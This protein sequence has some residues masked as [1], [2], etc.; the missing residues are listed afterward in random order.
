MDYTPTGP[1]PTPRQRL[2]LFHWM[3]SDLP[4]NAD[5]W[6]VWFRLITPEKKRG[7]WKIGVDS[8]TRA[9]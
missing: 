7:Y 6:L 1:M 3:Y 5:P 4:P 9:R 8:P 2:E